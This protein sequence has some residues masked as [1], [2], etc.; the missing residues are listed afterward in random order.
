MDKIKR[1]IYIDKI[2]KVMK[3]DY[4][5]FH[6]LKIYGFYDQLS[7]DEMDY[8]F[9]GVFEQPV[10]VEG[11]G[12]ELSGLGIF[13]ENR[14]TI[15]FEYSNGKWW[16]KEYDEDNNQIYY[17]SSNGNWVKYQYDKNGNPIYYE[18]SDGYW[19]KKEYDENGNIIYSEDY[20]GEI[21]N[22]R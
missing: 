8:V 2:I 9:S 20:N 16:K 5:L 18:N 10:K 17:E 4:P 11:Y 14:K 21:I 7:N 3:K 22:N 1:K 6:N 15:Y 13:N 19:W 12:Y